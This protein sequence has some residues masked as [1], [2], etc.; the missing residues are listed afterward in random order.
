MATAK[1]LAGL[2]KARA[3]RKS[4]A[5]TRAAN[6][7][8][9]MPE[10]VTTAKPDSADSA[11]PVKPVKPR[12]ARQSR[13]R[14]AANATRNAARRVGS[15]VAAAN[16]VY[17]GYAVGALFALAFLWLLAYLLRPD[18][19]LPDNLA[20]GHLIPWHP[21]PTLKHVKARP[22]Q[23]IDATTDAALRLVFAKIN[24]PS[25]DAACVG[26]ECERDLGCAIFTLDISK[27]GGGYYPPHAS[28]QRGQ[29][30]D[31]RMDNLS[32]DC[33]K[34]LIRRLTQYK[35][36]LFYDGPDSTA[37]T[38]YDGKHKTHM[39]ARFIPGTTIASD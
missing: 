37:Q 1:Q 20:G 6:K 7:P 35:W 16:P 21:G 5:R 34:R 23:Y 15:A 17:I 22:G 28:H 10:P 39:H 9:S 27:P 33:R 12:P 31:I 25:D 24:E 30:I 26:D 14:R 11:E 3:K 13:T 19:S 32:S 4:K 36:K 29:D 2:A 18:K 8:E 38:K